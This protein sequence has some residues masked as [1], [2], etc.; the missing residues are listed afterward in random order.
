[1][2]VEGNFTV[3]IPF[4]AN[5][6]N[7]N[8]APSI[9]LDLSFKDGRQTI[10]LTNFNPIALGSFIVIGTNA[11][12]TITSFQL[13][14]TSVEP[15]LVGGQFGQ[16]RASSAQIAG[17]FDECLTVSNGSCTSFGIDRATGPGGSLALTSTDTVPLPAALPLFATG[18]AALGLFGWRRK[19]K[20]AV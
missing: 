8:F 6:S 1:M 19:R 15:T 3:A 17:V 10:D 4:A 9:I 14:F 5:L 7:Q 16:I 12:G 11:S 13:G 20:Q 18:L 2:G